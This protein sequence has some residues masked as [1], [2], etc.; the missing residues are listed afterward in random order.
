MPGLALCVS[1]WTTRRRAFGVRTSATIRDE[2]GSA[3]DA[4]ELIGT[5]PDVRH[6]C[7]PVTRRRRVEE[8]Q[9]SDD[10]M[11]RGTDLPAPCA[12]DLACVDSSQLS[13]F[14]SRWSVHGLRSLFH[15]DGA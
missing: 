3:H 12:Q 15:S 9:G 8:L 2:E 7:G 14:A 1:S 5:L 4:E 10:Q 6:Q 13:G 11:K